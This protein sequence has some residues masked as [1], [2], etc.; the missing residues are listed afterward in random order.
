MFELIKNYRD[1]DKLRASFNELAEKTFGLNFENWYQNGFWTDNYNPYSIVDNGKVVANVSVNKT[2]MVWNGQKRTFIQLG[3]VMTEENYRNQGLIRK[4]MDEIETDYAGNIDGMYL[5]ANDSVV[6]FYPKFGF[7]PGSETV[8]FTEVSIDTDATIEQISM[9]TKKEW[10]ILQNAIM[11]CE[12][13]S[14]FEMV[15]N[16]GLYMFYISQF[17]QENVYFAKELNTYVIAE[18]EDSELF[19]HAVISENKVAL[20]DVIKAFGKTIKNVM[21]GF[22]PLDKKEFQMR[23][24]K[25]ENSTLFLK[26]EV[27]EGFEAEKVMFQTLAH[28]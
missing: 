8:Y 20:D 5:F 24:H 19:I 14:A 28:A 7:K 12:G 27:F 23:E 26:G 25:E 15:E 2:N 4:I 10:D 13:F 22:T 11:N 6:Q 9:S 3:T 17:M 21:L 16:S 1:N 18:I